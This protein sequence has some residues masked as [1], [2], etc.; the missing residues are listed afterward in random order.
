MSK[1]WEDTIKMFEESGED[2]NEIMVEDSWVED[3]KEALRLV[4]AFQAVLQGMR[5]DNADYNNP[6]GY[7]KILNKVNSAIGNTEEEPLAEIDQH[8]A[9]LMLQDLNTMK[10]RL[11]LAQTISD[12]N[13]GQKLKVQEKVATRKNFL[14]YKH[15][16]Q[17][18]DIAPEDWIKDGKAKDSFERL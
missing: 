18:G 11:E 13:R 15:L 3:N 6:T 1:H 8:E 4:D 14:L 5:V 17:L 9:D 10:S 2:P 16:S 7:T 12:I